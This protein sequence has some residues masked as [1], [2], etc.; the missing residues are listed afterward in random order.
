MKSLSLKSLV[1]VVLLAAGLSLTSC[2]AADP[3]P[4]GIYLR[5]VFPA[6]T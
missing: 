3:L 1:P 6:A 2:S 5:S 4:S